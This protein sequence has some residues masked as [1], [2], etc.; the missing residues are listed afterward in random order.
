MTRF[1]LVMPGI[2]RSA[3]ALAVIATVSTSAAPAAALT[4]TGAKIDKGAVQV[5]GTSAAPNATITWEGQSVARAGGG[6]R[7]HFETAILPPDCVS[8]TL[9]DGATTIPVVIQ[10][11][12]AQ[13]PPGEQGP[14]DPH[15]SMPSRWTSRQPQ[16][17][18]DR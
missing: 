18:S 3:F 7:F 1:A 6:G 2:R 9:S 17:S 11:C 10:F 16:R 4:V 8:A 15:T 5:K 12:A 13:G 14:P